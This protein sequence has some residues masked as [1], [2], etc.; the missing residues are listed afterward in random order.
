MADG[1]GK[2]Q[3]A[4]VETE[5]FFADSEFFA[6]NSSAPV[7]HSAKRDVGFI[8]GSFRVR[9]LGFRVW[10]GS[11]GRVHSAVAEASN[12]AEASTFAKATADRTMDRMADRPRLKWGTR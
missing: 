11:R 2:Q 12:F 1:D 3:K 6:V 9:R 7:L 5:S 10:G 4:E 8:R